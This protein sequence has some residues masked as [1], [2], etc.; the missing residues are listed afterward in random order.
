ME[1]IGLQYRGNWS[2]HAACRLFP[3]NSRFYEAFMHH[4]TGQLLVNSKPTVSSMKKSFPEGNLR[5][6]S[7]P[8]LRRGNFGDAS[9][10][11]RWSDENRSTRSYLEPFPQLEFPV[12]K[13]RCG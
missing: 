1:Y 2:L 4:V 5:M 11:P 9:V 12:G 10:N 3:R 7:I 13:D 8:R 6:E